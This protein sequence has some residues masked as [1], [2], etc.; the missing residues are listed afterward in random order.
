VEC[1]ESKFS[2]EFTMLQAELH[3]HGVPAVI[4]STGDLRYDPGQRRL[5]TYDAHGHRHRLPSFTGAQ[6]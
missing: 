4:C 3:R 5:Y 6:S 2:W 1:G